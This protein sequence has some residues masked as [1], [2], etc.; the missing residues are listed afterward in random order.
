MSITNLDLLFMTDEDEERFTI[1]AYHLTLGKITIQK[2]TPPLGY[3]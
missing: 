3:C 1:Q 2:S